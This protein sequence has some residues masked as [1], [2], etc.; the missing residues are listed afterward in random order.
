VGGNVR[1]HRLR[2]IWERA[3]PLRFTR[4]DRRRELWGHCSTCYYADECLG[5]CS[6]TAHS[7]LGRRGNNPFCHHRALVLLR[8]GRRERVRLVEAA[9]GLPF[10]HGRFDVIE[11]DWPMPGLGRARAVA[12][13]TADWLLD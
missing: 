2:E 11:E 9:A 1:E 13:G 7:L 4:D 12:E 5:G 10:D 6:W 8:R 3:E